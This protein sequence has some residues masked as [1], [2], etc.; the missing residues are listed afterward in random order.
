LWAVNGQQRKGLISQALDLFSGVSERTFFYKKKQVFNWLNDL[1]SLAISEAKE[2]L[3][4]V[5]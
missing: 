3:G 2:V 1:E 5:L 4:S